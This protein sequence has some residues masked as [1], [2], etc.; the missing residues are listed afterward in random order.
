[1]FAAARDYADRTS[2]GPA[3]AAHNAAVWHKMAFEQFLPQFH[4]GAADMLLTRFGLLLRQLLD[5][6]AFL[7][8]RSRFYRQLPLYHMKDVLQR[9]ALEVL[10]FDMLATDEDPAERVGRELGMD[11]R[12]AESVIKAA[13]K[14][15]NDVMAKRFTKADLQRLT[16]KVLPPQ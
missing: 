13:K 16:E 11:K 14:A 12:A 5:D 1:V 8:I 4:T 7:R 3:L 2:A 15:L 6:K 9:R 10:D